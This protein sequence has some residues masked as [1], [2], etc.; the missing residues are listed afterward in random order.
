MI[1]ISCL[2]PFHSSEKQDTELLE[3][4]LEITAASDCQPFFLVVLRVV[5]DKCG[6][7][8]ILYG[9]N[10][11]DLITGSCICSSEIEVLLRVKH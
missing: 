5:C 8:L 6:Q 1:K 11:W 7:K 3:T 9:K 2:R 10:G 4:G